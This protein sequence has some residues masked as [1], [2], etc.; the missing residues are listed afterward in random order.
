MATRG[1]ALWAEPYTGLSLWWGSGRSY[2]LRRGLRL[3]SVKAKG[4]ETVSVWSV[5]LV[6]PAGPTD[7]VFVGARRGGSHQAKG[8]VFAFVPTITQIK[9]NN[10]LKLITSPTLP[11]APRSVFYLLTKDLHPKFQYYTS[12]EKSSKVNT[13]IYLL[14]W[15]AWRKERIRN[16]IKIECTIKIYDASNLIPQV[17]VFFYLYLVKVKFL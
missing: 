11:L 2:G 14:K 1:P 4:V 15:N 16:V 13:W 5:P 17:L 7:A 12:I 6:C 3:V 9:T 8:G 10:K